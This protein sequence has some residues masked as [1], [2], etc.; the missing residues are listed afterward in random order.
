MS[1]F[2]AYTSWFLA[3]L[4]ACHM[5]PARAQPGPLVVGILPTLSPRVLINNYQPFRLYLEQTLQR[6]VEIV[7]ATDF[8][9]FHKSTM[10]GN[11]DVVVT[12]AHLGRLAQVEGGYIPLATF[13]S[14]N[15]ALLVTSIANPLKSTV[16]LRGQK[17]ATLDRFALI[18]AQ[19]RVWL[20][21]QGL[22]E[23]VDY[24]LLEAS[25]HNSAGY[26]VLSGESAL[27][28]ISPAGWK[29]MPPNIRD[30]LQVYATL[31][32]LPSLMWLANPSLAP[33]VPRLR[34]ALLA[35]SP[36]FP[37]GKQFFEVTGYQGMRDVLPEEMK[38][39]DIYTA[40]LKKY[41]GQ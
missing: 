23:Q 35:F 25:S 34:S 17:I 9:S 21:T 16:K 37:Q 32:A 27:A 31:P 14:T 15:R 10:A 30:G 1:K 2:L 18:A 12:A 20:E 19:A 8:T 38:S 22:Q 40:Y 28:I 13:K 7:T 6:P 39:L 3:F 24:R 11:Y 29:Q 33:E 4:V 36:G 41:L 5:L 26:S